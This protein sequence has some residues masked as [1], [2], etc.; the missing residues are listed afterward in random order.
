MR[1][2]HRSTLALF[3]ALGACTVPASHPP[4]LPA[5]ALCQTGLPETSTSSWRT[6]RGPDFTL[7][8]P[9][10]WRHDAP[11]PRSG[12]AEIGAWASPTDTLVWSGGPFAEALGGWGPAP[13]YSSQRAT[14]NAVTGRAVMGFGVRRGPRPNAYLMY[15]EW[16]GLR[17][18][19]W[20][21]GSDSSSVA[22]EIARTVRFRGGA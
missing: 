12:A 16:P 8:I 21:Q 2:M 19:I 6:V 20:G 11:A 9:P 4:P 22:W 10:T 14:L 3:L 13:E 17:V 1:R 18:E 5:S 7:C 15:L